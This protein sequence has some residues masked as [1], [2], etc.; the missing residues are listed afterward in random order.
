MSGLVPRAVS[1]FGFGLYLL[2]S[3]AGAYAD[4]S[5]TIGTDWRAEASHGGIYEAQAA[6]IYK[7]YHLNVTIVQGGPNLNQAQLLAAGHYDFIVSSNSFEPLNFVQNNVPIVVVAAGFQKDPQVLIAHQ[8]A[9][10]DRLEAMKGKPI[11]ISSDARPSYWQFLRVKFGFS[12]DQ[13]RPYNYSLQPFLVDKKAIVQGYL[14]DEP[15]AIELAS[16]EKPVTILLAD[17]GYKSS[18]EFI[19][20]T[21]ANI[22]SKPDVVQRFVTATMEGWKQ[23]LHGDPTGANDLIKKDNPE[24]T[25]AILAHSRAG[26]IAGGLVES[27]DA[28][29]LGIGAM[30]DSRWQEFADFAIGAGIFPKDIAYKKA[31]TLRFLSTKTAAAP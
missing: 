27:G 31:Y 23:Y 21:E 7:K 26:I 18:A 11:M 30:T 22:D 4:D 17:H 25:D 12:D 24:M 1:L 13:I 6:G 10:N 15:Y 5:V 8:G 20:T 28:I 9:G 14:T 3:A 2:A 16:G 29:N 19:A